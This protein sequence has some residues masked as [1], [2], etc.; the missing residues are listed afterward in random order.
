ME[1]KQGKKSIEYAT[2]SWN[3]ISGCLASDCAVRRYGFC[4]AEKMAKRLRGRAGYDKDFPFK[5]TFHRDKLFLPSKWRG[6]LRIDSCFMGDIAYSDP[7]WLL[8]VFLQVELNSQH[9]FYFL[10]KHPDIL[11]Q[12]FEANSFPV[13]P[14]NAWLGVTVN[15]QRDIWRVEWLRYFDA[16]IRYVSFE[17]LYD[18]V[19]RPVFFNPKDCRI[20]WFIIGAQTNPSYQPIPYWISELLKIA[21]S[22]GIPVFMKNNLQFEPKR[23]EFP[24]GE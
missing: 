9:R 2:K 22:Y 1:V 3:P 5:P 24:P 15:L 6:N 20:E 17:P 18:D 19:T 13:L 14:K 21:D 10:T 7:D 16:S 4:W 12:K 23:Y 8:D 11:L